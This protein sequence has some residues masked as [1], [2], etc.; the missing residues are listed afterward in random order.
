MGGILDAMENIMLN[1]RDHGNLA[2]EAVSD[3]RGG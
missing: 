3:L 2:G 1:R